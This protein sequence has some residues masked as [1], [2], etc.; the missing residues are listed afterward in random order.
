MKYFVVTPFVL[1]TPQGTATLP[2]GQ[3]LEL[4][5]DQAA[6]LADKV[7]LLP[8]PNG[9]R[10]LPQYCPSYGGWCSE[11]LPGNN[12]PAG[13]TKCDSYQAA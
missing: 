4:S 13:C 7:E 12:Y 10:D 6:R 8:P 11:K 1:E 9:G 3:V 5:R 2:A